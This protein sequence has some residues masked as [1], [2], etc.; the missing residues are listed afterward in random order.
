MKNCLL[1]VLLAMTLLPSCRKN[2]V[3]MVRQEPRIETGDL[4]FVGIPMNY[5][6]EDMA[7]ARQKKYAIP[8][9]QNR[10][11]DLL[12]STI[13]EHK[14]T[15]L[16]RDELYQRITETDDQIAAIERE[17]LSTREQWSACL[18]HCKTQKE[19]LKECE[20]HK[21]A[22]PKLR[23][24]AVE[25][26]MSKYLLY[27]HMQELDLEIAVLLADSTADQAILYQKCADQDRN[28]EKCKI[29][30]W[31]TPALKV[32]NTH[33]HVK[34]IEK[35]HADR[36]EEVTTIQEK[37]ASLD[38]QIDDL[39][40][41]N[42]RFPTV[43]VCD[44]IDDLIKELIEVHQLALQ[45]KIP[46]P[47]IKN[48]TYQELSDSYQ[49]VSRERFA[50]LRRKAEQRDGLLSGLAENMRV[51]GDLEKE[52]PITPETV[53]QVIRLC[54]THDVLT[55]Q[56]QEQGWENARTMDR[57]LGSIRNRFSCYQQ[58]I[59]VDASIEEQIRQNSQIPDE[60][61]NHG[62]VIALLTKQEALISKCKQSLWPLPSL[63]VKHPTAERLAHQEKVQKQKAFQEEKERQLEKAAAAARK[64][65]EIKYRLIVGAIG[66]CA[67]MVGIVICIGLS[68]KGKIQ[69]PFSKEYAL[70]SNAVE[71]QEEL[72][73]LGFTDIKMVADDSGWKKD[74]T[75]LEMTVD[76]QVAFEKGK[77][78]KPETKII[79]YYSS[80]N[81][82]D[83][84]PVLEGWDSSKYQDV[85]RDLKD[86][87]FTN[88][89][90]DDVDGSSK[91]HDQLVAKILLNGQEY[92]GGDCFLP[93][94]APIVITHYTYKIKIGADQM[95]FIGQ[96]HTAVVEKLKKDGFMNV[97][98]Q[99]ITG[100]W[101][102][103]NS[104]VGVL[105]NGSAEFTDSDGVLPN[106][107]ILVKYSS[108]D[109]VDVTRCLEDWR[110]N[111]ASKI[112]EALA[113]KG[114]TNVTI[115]KVSTTEIAQDQMVYEVKI[116]DAVFDRGECYVQ[117]DAPI[118]ISYYDLSITIG[119][120]ASDLKGED[121]L[122]IVS[123]LQAK[124]FSDIVI[125]RSDDLLTGWIDRP[126]TIKSIS[127][128][129]VSDFTAS[130][131][132]AHDDEIVIVVY[133]HKGK[134]YE[135]ITQVE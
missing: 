101:A 68:R 28:I 22:V 51:L 135:E 38:K 31:D 121:Y 93:A 27:L 25:E 12:V 3:S 79:I 128:N 82:I 89:T 13:M 106:S 70:G 134:G 37:A 90:V 56:L 115:N 103:G 1:F 112:Q 126:G 81:R 119:T 58:M 77:Y 49:V 50:A 114:A 32:P 116:G 47:R 64:R 86:A 42:T 83:V 55:A 29:Y 118:V 6:E 87:G 129:G 71:L 92:Y 15:A 125:K 104:V 74:D 45:K 84:S 131:T 23:Y 113:T 105:V 54:Q 88:I 2:D 80:Q 41:S 130:D 122:A 72:T 94:S 69:F 34:R 61:I 65:M 63:M 95:T 48:I 66:V 20:L 33:Q 85:Q 124:G 96:N 102:K 99:K 16:A 39:Y 18:T 26:L 97:H 36:N 75:I 24:P 59:E 127:I 117:K 19:Q 11:A 73:E 109:R 98:E 53:D 30:G 9:I 123:D 44:Q 5:G 43:S 8:A 60:E 108:D 91:D 78:Y 7:Q 110:T 67:L 40:T 35:A 107:K 14:K 76:D 120:S 111:T 21:W 132:F 57:N 133:T 10:D 100:G 46:L 62:P 4:L 17:A 52:S